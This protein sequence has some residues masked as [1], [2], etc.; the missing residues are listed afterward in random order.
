MM[1]L[2][3]MVNAFEMQCVGCVTMLAVR[4]GLRSMAWCG[5]DALRFVVRSMPCFL[6]ARGC[7]IGYAAAIAEWCG[8]VLCVVVRHGAVLRAWVR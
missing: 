4:C 5:A 1:Q 2:V 3:F 7:A 6:S 8:A